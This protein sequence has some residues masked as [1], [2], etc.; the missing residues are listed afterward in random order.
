MTQILD[1]LVAI[2]S[3]VEH[4]TLEC[5]RD[6]ISSEWRNEA[7]RTLWRYLLG[8]GGD[9]KTLH[10]AKGLVTELSRPPQPEDGE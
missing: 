10:V 2:S 4:L 6:V 7:D 1:S 9:V 5:K 8:P 3:V